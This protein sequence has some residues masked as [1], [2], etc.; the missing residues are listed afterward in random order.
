MKRPD[1]ALQLMRAEPGVE[2]RAMYGAKKVL[3]KKKA[4]CRGAGR[5]DFNVPRFLRRW[6]A[7]TQKRPTARRPLGWTAASVQPWL[8]SL[9]RLRISR[10]RGPA[11]VPGSLC[12]T[13]S[14]DRL[15][16]LGWIDEAAKPDLCVD[17]SPDAHRGLV[18]INVI[19]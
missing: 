19:S 16:I 18:T 6:I 3:V 7:A 1:R 9:F 14:D 15:E 11:G 5:C 12:S 13:L 2:A 8:S 17:R 10:A 4:C